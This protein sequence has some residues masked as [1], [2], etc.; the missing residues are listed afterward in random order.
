MM[1]CSWQ[2]NHDESRIIPANQKLV[3]EFNRRIASG[4]TRFVFYH[5]RKDWVLE[6]AKNNVQQLSRIQW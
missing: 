1:H 2:S 3:K 4:A 5:E 6:A